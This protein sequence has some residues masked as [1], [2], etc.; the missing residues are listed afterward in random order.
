MKA[1]NLVAFVDNLNE[2]SKKDFAKR[3]QSSSSHLHDYRAG[4]T[5]NHEDDKK[6]NFGK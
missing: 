5:F 1:I 2:K 4:K 6:N 3:F